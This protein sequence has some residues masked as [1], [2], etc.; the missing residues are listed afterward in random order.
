VAARLA[1]RCRRERYDAVVITTLSGWYLSTFRKFLLPPNTRVVSWHHGW[2]E[3][4]WEQM[5][6]EERNGGHRF[7]ARFKFYYGQIILGA[8]RQ[9]LKTQDGALFTS[10]EECNWVRAHYPAWA[11]KVF[12]QPNGVSET[13]YYPQRFDRS[14]ESAPVRLLFVGYWDPWRKGK[15]YLI[16]AFARL[17]EKYSSLQLTLAGTKLTEQDILP[18]FP[19]AARGQVHV[20]PHINEADL[21]AVYQSHDIFVLPALFEG[22][23]LVVLEAMAAAM[24]VVTT[25]NNGMRDLITDGQDGMLLPRLDVGALVDAVSALV[26]SPALREQLGRE[27][28]RTVREDFSWARATDHFEA[29]MRKILAGRS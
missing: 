1:E 10:N 12:Y 3:M 28:Y 29:S 13:Y 4:M 25:N 21:V 19:E 20:I 2:E 6:T 23:P 11:S 22:M 9:S 7:S 8:N 5:L 14:I 24:P 27:A 17:Q 26:D 16:E 18:E 15:K